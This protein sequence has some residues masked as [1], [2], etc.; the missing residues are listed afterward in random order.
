MLLHQRKLAEYQQAECGLYTYR[1][2]QVR[3]KL[4]KP[5]QMDQMAIK[6]SDLPELDH[7]L[8]VRMLA[9][10][11]SM[12]KASSTQLRA[13]ASSGEEGW[14]CDIYNITYWFLAVFAK[15]LAR[16]SKLSE[17]GYPHQFFDSSPIK[18]GEL[19]KN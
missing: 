11:D 14:E 12:L 5:E 16:S 4:W 2:W 9:F 8:E 3:R 17:S 19:S 1:E 7:K 18:N 15:E 13:E 10:K 6:L